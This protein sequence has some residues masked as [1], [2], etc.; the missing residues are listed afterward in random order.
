[1]KYTGRTTEYATSAMHSDMAFSACSAA[2]DTQTA[3]SAA[4]FAY[5]SMRDTACAVSLFTLLLV[6]ALAA[7]IGMLSPVYLPILLVLDVIYII[8]VRI[9]IPPHGKANAKMNCPVVA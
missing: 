3:P 8:V 9:I 6:A 5:D 7:F 1:M 2:A 4:R